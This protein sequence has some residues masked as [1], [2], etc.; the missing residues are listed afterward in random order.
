MPTYTVAN[1]SGSVG[2][3]TSVVTSA[4][5]LAANGL[6]VRVID[7]DPQA[8]ASTWPATRTSPAR[9]SPTS[10]ASTPPSTTSNDLPASSRATPK[11]ESQSMA[12][13]QTGRSTTSRSCQPPVPPSTSSWSNCPPSPAE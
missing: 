12:A 3:T 13:P 7:L 5:L 10:Y 9:P 4:V 8:N 2:K 11:T 6:R 1:M